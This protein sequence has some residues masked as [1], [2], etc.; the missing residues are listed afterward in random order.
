MQLS[1]EHSWRAVS[2]LN[3]YVKRLEEYQIRGKAS[4]EDF[5][6]TSSL[7]KSLRKTEFKCSFS[8]PV[9]LLRTC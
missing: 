1:R 4:A 8:V 2:Q 7:Q 9:Q 5:L 3:Q 6:T